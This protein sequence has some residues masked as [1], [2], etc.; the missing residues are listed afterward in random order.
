MGGGERSKKDRSGVVIKRVTENCKLCEEKFITRGNH[1]GK[2]NV[3]LNHLLGVRGNR[4]VSD[5]GKNN[6]PRKNRVN[7]GIGES[8]ETKQGR[9]FGKVKT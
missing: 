9:M 3:V 5:V 1:Y 4:M 2:N 8:S 6:N 7:G